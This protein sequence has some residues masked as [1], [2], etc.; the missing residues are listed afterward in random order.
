MTEAFQAVPTEEGLLPSNADKKT[1]EYD[2]IFSFKNN[3][4]DKSKYK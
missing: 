2:T 4:R 1:F 3:A